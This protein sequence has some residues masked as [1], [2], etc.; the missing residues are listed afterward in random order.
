MLTTWEAE[1]EVFDET[2]AAAY[3]SSE[4][5]T[6]HQLHKTQELNISCLCNSRYTDT[7]AEKDN[8]WHRY[9]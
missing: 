6:Q 2:L 5:N 1:L 3:F 4:V 9:R 7:A 8:R